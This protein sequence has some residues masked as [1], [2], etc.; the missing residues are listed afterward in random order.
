MYETKNSLKG[1]RIDEINRKKWDVFKRR[2][3]KFYQ[4][5]KEFWKKQL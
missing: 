1:E 2:K 5:A 3:R 4:K